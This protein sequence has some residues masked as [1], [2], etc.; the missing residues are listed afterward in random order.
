MD[1][2]SAPWRPSLSPGG[3]E[4]TVTDS[5]S[6]PDLHST[7]LGPPHRHDLGPC[8]EVSLSAQPWT[9]RIGEHGRGPTTLLLDDS[10]AHSSLRASDLSKTLP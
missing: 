2:L 5:N 9:Y 4:P 7:S 10:D 8:Q 1:Y 6:T 3:R